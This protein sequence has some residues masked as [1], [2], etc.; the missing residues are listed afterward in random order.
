MQEGSG[1]KQLRVT[2]WWQQQR[3]HIQLALL[4][5]LIIAATLIFDGF[6]TARKQVK[7]I[8][9]RIQQEALALSKNIAVTSAYQIVN[10]DLAALEELL[11]KSVEFPGVSF[12]QI[13]DP[14]G[15]PLGMVYKTAD[16][17]KVQYKIERVALPSWLDTGTQAKIILHRDSMLVWQPIRTSSTLG[18]L[19]ISYDLQNL[20]GIRQSIWIDNL[21]TSVYAIAIDLVIL[22]LILKL[23]MRALKQASNFAL[24][25]DKLEGEILLAPSTSHEINTLTT[26]LNQASQTLYQQHKEI[27]QTN[28]YLSK[29]AQELA[30]SKLHLEQRVK[31]RTE[32][33]T[34]Q[35]NHDSLTQLYNRHEFEN[36]LQETLNHAAVDNNEHFLCY[37]DLDQF[38][39]VN[40]TCGHI[41]GDEL[42][43]QISHMLLSVLRKSD[44]LAR[45]GGDE[46]GVILAD[47]PEDQAQRIA[48]NLLESIHKFRFSWQKS[49]FNIGASIGLVRINKN[50]RDITSLLSAADI[51]CYSAKDSGRNQ[52][53][54]Y[55]PDDQEQSQRRTEI[56]WASRI[57]QSIEKNQLCLLHQPI[58][59]LRHFTAYQPH[60]EILVRMRRDDGELIT[61]NAFLPAAERYSLITNIDRWVIDT[62]LQTLNQL[63]NL[64]DSLPLMFSINLSGPSLGSR[65]MR[66]YLVNKLREY[67]I[68]AGAVCIEITE[69][70]AITHLV[71]AIELIKKLKEEGCRFALDDFGTGLASFS[72]LK[73]LPVDYLK[74]DGSFV[75]DILHDTM[76]FTIVESVNNL[77]HALGLKTIAEFVESDAIARKLKTMGVDFAQGYFIGEPVPLDLN[78]P[79][80]VSQK[81][82]Q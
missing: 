40:D 36:R 48:K 4:S 66:D 30:I 24:R 55:T 17:I 11:L 21:L 74:I 14:E 32:Q 44:T 1:R 27:Q 56:L 8:Y 75:K 18:W 41:A 12:I 71:D 42:L 43:R 6:V 37:I 22:L 15:N 33:L 28:K 60:Y 51:A 5:A 65:V 35:A 61:P 29:T 54:L 16:D 73:S 34:W 82:Q 53:K 38:K 62:S 59:P 76:D 9:H 47:C 69:T 67:Q 68:P 26:A 45:L 79:I 50:T 80:K 3:L 78:Y 46:F 2:H 20:A 10:N 13:S 57:T 7:I 64:P 19:H 25:L 49:S 31:E 72:Y 58:Q 77:A 39:V 70:A 23:P 52:V 63:I 81:N